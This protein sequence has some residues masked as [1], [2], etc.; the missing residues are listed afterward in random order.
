MQIVNAVTLWHLEEIRSLFSEYAASLN[1]NLCFQNFSE[2]LAH[3]PGAYAPPRGCLLLARVNNYPAGCIA[4]RPLAENQCEL[5]R[6]YVRPAFR[7]LG[8]GERL[9]KTL[10][11]IAQEIGY[12]KMFLDT[13]GEMKK[14]QA[15]YKALGFVDTKPYYY[16]PIPDAR[17]MARDL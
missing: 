16:N 4:L 15:L 14:A 9:V 6:L 2:E 11:T 8:L 17:F 1:F 7:G 10:M 5:K 12:G 13:V 3:L